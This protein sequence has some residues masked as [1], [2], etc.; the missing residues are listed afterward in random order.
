MARR[1]YLGVSGIAKK[2]KNGYIG[3][4]GKARKITKVYTGVN[5]TAK[6]VCALNRYSITFNANGG[7]GTMTNQE[8]EGLDTTVSTTIKA[9]AFTRTGYRF[10]NWN[11]KPDGSGT[12]YTSGQTISLTANTTLYAQWVALITI[13]YW[14]SCNMGLVANSW[15]GGAEGESGPVTKNGVPYYLRFKITD[16]NGTVHSLVLGDLFDANGNTAIKT[17]TVPITSKME[18]GLVNKYSGNLCEVRINGKTMAGPAEYILSSSQN[19]VYPYTLSNMSVRFEWMV[20]GAYIPFVQDTRQSYWI[21]H[22]T[23]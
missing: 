6:L 5:G 23:T 22:I 17:L 1:G 11:T 3:I 9:N 21:C 2:L 7:S 14:K 4:D 12:A 19:Y 16:P 10:T 20:T 18:I 13:T 8:A 15:F